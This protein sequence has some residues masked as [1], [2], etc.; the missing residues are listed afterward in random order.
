MWSH[1]PIIYDKHALWGISHWGQKHQQFYR[2]AVNRESAHDV[3]SKHRILAITKLKIV[4]W[5]NY[6]HLDWITIHRN[7]DKLY[8][9]KEGDYNRLHLRDIKDMLLLLHYPQKACGRSSI[10]CRKLLK[11]AQPHKARYNKDKKNRLMRIDELYKFS[12]GTLNDVR[13]ALNDILKRIRMEYLPQTV[14][15]NVD[16]ERAGAMIQAID[17]Q[18]RNI[19]YKYSNPMNQPEPE[20]STQGYPVD[21]V[22]VLRILKDGGKDRMLARYEETN[23]V[24]NW[25]KCHFMVKEGIVLGHKISGAGIEVDRAKID[26]IAKLPYPTNVKGVR[27]FLGHAGFYRSDFTVGVVLGQRIDGNFKPIYYGSKTLNNAQEHYTTTEK[28]LLAVVFSFDKFRQYLI[29]SKTVVYTD[30][31]AMKYLF[32]KEDAKQRLIRFENPYL[33]TFTE[34]EITDEFPDEHLMIL[35]AELNNYE[36]WYADYVNYIVGKIV[37]PNWTPEKR[38]RFFSQVKNYFWDEP[39][40]FKLCSNNVM[41][42]CVAGNEILKILAHCHTG[43]TGGHHSASITGRKVYESRF[44]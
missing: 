12:D 13:C 7:D 43:P 8:T 35:K 28:E 27:S 40:A 16:R 39:Y 32:S 4:E 22:E 29:L 14:W 3:Y 19:R 1:V 41:R 20:G 34:E 26:V 38:R 23:L 31:S 42:R 15:R 17:R 21:S 10:R 9:F 18:L 33:G 44:Y 11:E 5:H 6:K 30:H 37:P 36:P 25:E 24:L 2:F